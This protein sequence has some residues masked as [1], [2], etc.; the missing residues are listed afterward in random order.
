MFFILQYLY[1]GVK[2]ITD[3]VARTFQRSERTK[4]HE[5][6]IAA[7]ALIADHEKDLDVFEEPISY[8]YKYQVPRA[9]GVSPLSL[10]LSKH[11]LEPTTITSPSA[12]QTDASKAPN[13]NT[14][15]L[16]HL[17]RTA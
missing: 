2:N 11:Q 15:W 13:P 4:P 14:L 5:A 1:L 7:T 10:V 17:V 8:A 16:Q 9:I 12:L 3:V 6:D